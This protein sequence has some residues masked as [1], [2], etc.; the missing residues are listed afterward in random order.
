MPGF[1]VRADQGNFGGDG[2]DWAGDST[3]EFIYSYTWQIINLMDKNI[4]AG[5]PESALIYA[6]DMILPTFTVGIEHQ[7]G[8]SLEYKFAKNVSWDDIKITFY[9]SKGMIDILRDWRKQIWT[10]Q[11]GLLQADQYKKESLIDIVTPN[12]GRGVAPAGNVAAAVAGTIWRLFGSWPSV[13]R[14]G[15]LT[16]TNSDVKIVEITVTYDFASEIGNLADDA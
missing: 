5:G 15:D 10:A 4:S 13:I 3:A 7:Q 6:K 2:Q 1:M 9:D 11:Q 14:H 8:A 12:W 16:Y